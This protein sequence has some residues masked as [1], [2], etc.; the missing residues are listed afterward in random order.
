MTPDPYK[1]FLDKFG[2]FTEIQ[3][4][5]FAAIEKGE[6]CIITAP[7]GSGK[8]EA[9]MLPVFNGI[10]KRKDAGGIQ[11]IYV[12]PLRAL[13]RDLMKRL[14]AMAK[15]LG[16]SIATRHG[17]TTASERQKQAARPPQI[18]ITTPE[19]VQN[20]FLSARL[21]SA[22]A[23][24][25]VVIVD[26][27]HE[28]YY[29]KR[30][31]QL[32]IALERL[33]ELSP[34]YQRIGISATIGS[35]D[36]AR[37]FLFG[38]K[39]C[40]IVDAKTEKKI[41]I[42][43][44]MPQRP[45][46]EYKEFREKF[47]LDAETL[48]RLERIADLVKQSESTLI[49]ANTR[50]VVESLGSKLI[51]LNGLMPFGSIGI[52][53]GSLDKEERV[54][55]ENAF[56]EGR[57]KGIVSTSSLELGIDIGSINMVLQYGS[58]RQ[59]T[60]LLQR[61]GRGGHRE[62][63]ISYG[64]IIVANYIDAIE[65]AAI[66]D[67]IRKAEVEEQKMERLAMDVLANQIC[68]MALEYG[69]IPVAKAYGI[70]KRAAP[71]AD[72]SLTEFERLVNF[73][74]DEHLIKV[75][76]GAIG[77]GFRGRD[78]F[79]SNI[80]V[81]PDSVRFFVKDAASNRTIATLDEKFVANYLD[82]GSVFITK[83]LP[84]RIVSIDEGTIFVE[85]SAEFEA[86]IPDWEGED[87]PVSRRTS[88][89][90]F[91]YIAKGFAESLEK[92]IEKTLRKNLEEFML[93]QR[94]HF[95]PD[96]ATICVEELDDYS[97]VYTGLGKLA[98]EFVAKLMG[99]AASQ[100]AGSRLLVKSTPYA[101]IVDY[102]GARK[103]PDMRRVMEAVKNYSESSVFGTEGIIPGTELF[104]YKF[105]MVCK[106][107]GIVEKRAVVTK[108]DAERLVKFYANSPIFDET[109]RDLRKN[110]LDV[111]TAE[112]LFAGLRKGTISIFVA[113]GRRSPLTEEILK[114][115]YRYRELLLP[116]I[117]DDAEINEFRSKIDG[118]RVELFCTFCGLDFFKDTD[119]ERKEKLACPRCLSPMVCVYGE[120]KAASVRKRAAGKKLTAAEEAA[121]HVA[122]R[123]ASLVESYGDR[124]IAALLTYGI[125]I[126]TAARV[127]KQMRQG[128]KQF[129][130]DLIEAQK[131]FIKTKKYWK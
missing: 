130:I 71:Y 42:D 45:E 30:G 61:V 74:A 4:S 22:M 14:E 70:A 10:L 108:R 8:T 87:I 57:V 66:I 67:Q 99:H 97:L 98:N 36:E 60:R 33:A 7:T 53:H 13:N 35:L 38:D 15:E 44:E 91:E 49:F 79:F 26:E 126:T 76:E 115:S 102:S 131:S 75:K 124:A 100:A 47:D 78:Y 2:S 37:K 5:A 24:T 11:A 21:K 56:K 16:V 121:R 12:T 109:L 50:Q 23:S 77:M 58:P 9:A 51:Y 93:A 62:K 125:G 19:T 105:V 65:S 59:V 90:V 3:S 112:R 82:E 64:K 28:L 118:R 29:N 116:A 106:L 43:I 72:L 34:S 20:L 119:L 94:A 55:T 122:L 129:I 128:E 85:P 63:E 96:A 46:K 104:R 52:H 81:I 27:L 113:G 111:D 40:R 117:P 88:Q 89:R 73:L 41:E 103:K 80:S 68:G 107:F 25:R 69:K 120:D 127:L 32:A 86:A 17:D 48:A 110:Y 31:A 54:G 84:W 83:G 101:I 95:A 1:L 18:L 114:A 6:N 92:P 39:A 123:E